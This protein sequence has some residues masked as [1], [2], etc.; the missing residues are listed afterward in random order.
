[1]KIVKLYRIDDDNGVIN[2]TMRKQLGVTLKGTKSVQ[3]AVNEFHYVI[4]EA[5]KEYPTVRNTIMTTSRVKY[6]YE[7]LIPA[8][9]GTNSYYLTIDIVKEFEGLLFQCHFM[10]VEEK[11]FFDEKVSTTH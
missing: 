2:F 11:P 3:E 7:K 6:Y 4:D 1:M 10:L 5:V 8:Y 9:S